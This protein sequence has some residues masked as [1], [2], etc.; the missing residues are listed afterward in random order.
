MRASRSG[1]HVDSTLIE[2]GRP[3]KSV[4]CAEQSK[5]RH[6]W[7][8]ADLRLPFSLI[9]SLGQPTRTYGLKLSQDPQFPYFNPLCFGPAQTGSTPGS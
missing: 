4:S 9:P 3:A 5:R 6:P 7:R 1:I 2:E 8:A